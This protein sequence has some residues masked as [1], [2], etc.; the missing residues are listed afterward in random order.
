MKFLTPS[1]AT[2]LYSQ[3]REPEMELWSGHVI[4]TTPDGVIYDKAGVNVE[5]RICD[6]GSGMEI[7]IEDHDGIEKDYSVLNDIVYEED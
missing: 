1:A 7:L 2:P 5:V 6:R 3:S 4:V